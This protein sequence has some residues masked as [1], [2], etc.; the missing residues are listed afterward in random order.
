MYAF[1]QLGVETIINGHKAAMREEARGELTA[2][3]SRSQ[4]GAVATLRQ[5]AV[6]WL[7]AHG[8]GWARSAHNALTAHPNSRQRNT[9]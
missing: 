9:V 5:R 4:P 7:S 6:A 2:T 1:D 3:A 8:A